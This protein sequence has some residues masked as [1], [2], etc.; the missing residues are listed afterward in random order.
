MAR[1]GKRHV[2]AELASPRLDL[3]PLS[4]K[5]ADSKATSK[6]ASEAS[7]PPARTG[8]EEAEGEVRL[9]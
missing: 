1:N 7:A 3:T 5:E 4:K 8:C 2:E 9:Q 6:S